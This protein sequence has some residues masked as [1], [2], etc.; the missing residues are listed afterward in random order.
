MRVG[1]TFQNNDYITQ[2]WFIT[3]SRMAVKE[4]K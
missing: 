4:S 3:N 2:P 1:G